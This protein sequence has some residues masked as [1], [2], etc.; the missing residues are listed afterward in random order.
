MLSCAIV[1]CS[2]AVSTTIIE[3]AP[4][5]F[6]K[7]A[8]GD[9]GEIDIKLHKQYGYIYDTSEYYDAQNTLNFTRI[10]LL[11]SEIDFKVTFR[12]QFYLSFVVAKYCTDFNL[13]KLE[14]KKKL[15][16]YY[17]GVRLCPS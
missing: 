5:I 9:H 16:E 14:L 4:I 15:L 13:P 7:Q 8:E 6:L 3:R 10:N 17:G 11:L 12:Q 1:V 2:T